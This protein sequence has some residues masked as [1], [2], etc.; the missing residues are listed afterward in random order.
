MARWKGIE[1]YMNNKT[2][3]NKINNQFK[4]FGFIANL[5]ALNLLLGEG[6]I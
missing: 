2:V 5:E 3:T 4:S 6:Y 1:N